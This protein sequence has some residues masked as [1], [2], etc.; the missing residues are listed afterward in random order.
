[1]IVNTE[2]RIEQEPLHI[3]GRVHDSV[4]VLAACD[5]NLFRSFWTVAHDVNTN[6]R[7]VLALKSSNGTIPESYRP[8]RQDPANAISEPAAKRCKVENFDSGTLHGETKKSIEDEFR[9]GRV[10]LLL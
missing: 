2:K 5:S 10:T 7:C 1:M 8:A 6:L 3:M 4:Y 9:W